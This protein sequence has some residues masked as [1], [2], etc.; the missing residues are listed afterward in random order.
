M[1]TL[2][3]KSRNRLTNPRVDRLIFIYTNTRSLRGDQGDKLNDKKKKGKEV[4]RALETPDSDDGMELDLNDDELEE[5]ITENEMLSVLGKRKRT[6]HDSE[7][8]DILE[9]AVDDWSSIT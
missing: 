8:E 3:N 9:D 1:N 7:V 5:L 2:H 4:L 6:D